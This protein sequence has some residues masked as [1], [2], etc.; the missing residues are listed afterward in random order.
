MG[1]GEQPARA[2]RPVRLQGVHLPAALL[3][4]DLATR[5]T[6][7][8]PGGRR[9]RRRRTLEVS[10]TTTASSPGGLPLARPAQGRTR[11]SASR[12]S[13]CSTGSRRRT[14]RRWPGSSATCAWGNK[15]KLPEHA[16]LNLIEAFDT[17]TLGPSRV[18]HDV[19]GNAYEYLL[20]KFADESGKKA[21]EFFTPRSV[22]RL[23][24]RDPRPAAGRDGLRPGLRLGR[25]ARRG[26]QRGH[27]GGRSIAQLRLYGQEVNLTTAA[28]AR[29]NL[30]LHDIEDFR[31]RPRRHAAR[32][33]VPRRAGRLAAVRHRD[34]QSAVL[35]SRTGVREIWVD[36]PYGP[37]RLRRPAHRERR[38]RLGGAH[39][40]VDEA[41]DR[42]RRRRH[43]A[44]RAVPRRG[45]ERDPQC[46]LEADLLDA[47]IGLPPNLFYSTSIPACLLIFRATKPD[48]APRAS[49]F[50]G[51]LQAL[52]QGP[53]PE[54][55]G[56]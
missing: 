46:L 33:E 44:R 40:A 3:Q 56:P 54:P 14:R 4:A 34:R 25:D 15:E 11:T 23:L 42:S 48:G 19:L 20:K 10:P 13:G 22:V 29:M 18:G 31:I 6:R 53:E 32:P 52:Q 43:A 28:I 7:S 16:L 51:R 8:T 45:G 1:G 47:V 36:D 41:G 37:R 5:G 27:R 17:S 24:T 9:L 49:C 55:D 30:F 2:G 50:R 39:G 26:G 12:F 35:R 38:L 21:G